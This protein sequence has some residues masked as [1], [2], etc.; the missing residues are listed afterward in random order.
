MKNSLAGLYYPF[1]RCVQPT[2]LKQ[3][4][5]VFDEVTFADPVDDD[6]RR[7]KLFEDLESYDTGFA[8]YQGI[9]EALP[10]L[11]RQG[12]IRRFDPGIHINNR[13][14]AT[15]SAVDD[16]SDPN[17]LQAASNPQKHGM[18]SIF[19]DGQP[20]WQVFK[21]KLPDQFINTLQTRSDFQ[22]HLIQ[23]GDSRTSWS[24]SYAAGSAIG[25]ALHL[26]I[27][28]DLGLAPITDSPMHHRLM[29]MKSAR[30]LNA[31]SNTSRF[32]TRSR[33]D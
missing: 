5:L 9:D 33:V 26:D 12:C 22:K 2:S 28:G 4:L 25:I 24:L 8:N 3:M 17:W 20:S 18:P 27:A 19:I 16:L 15:N 10:E 21:P 29:L 1:S 14:L 6:Q 13:F 11:L 31:N 30:A 23:E 7:A 32:R